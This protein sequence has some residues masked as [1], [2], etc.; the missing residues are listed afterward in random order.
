MLESPEPCRD[1]ILSYS[2][3]SLELSPEACRDGVRD[4]SALGSRVERASEGRLLPLI[5][6]EKLKA[7]VGLAPLNE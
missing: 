4:R 3:P 5:G 7:G 2:G 6:L 1:G